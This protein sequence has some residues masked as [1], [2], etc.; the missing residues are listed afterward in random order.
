MN[1]PH[2]AGSYADPDAKTERWGGRKAQ[3][4]VD[5][6]IQ[7]YGDL[8]INCGLPNADSADHIIPRADGGAVFDI[9][10]LGPSHRR[11]N[12]SRG[13]KPLRPVGIPVESGVGFFS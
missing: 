2:G 5:L 10:N 1:L 11:C 9:D 13:R 12:Y 3:A 4:Y 6:T 7:T 8:C